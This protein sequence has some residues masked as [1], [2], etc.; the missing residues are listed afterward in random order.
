MKGRN[1]D[2]DDVK[3]AKD[4]LDSYIKEA[5]LITK[6]KMQEEIEAIRRQQND[7]VELTRIFE[8]NPSL[9]QHEEAIKALAKT[10]NSALEDIIVKYNFLSSDKLKKAKER[11]IVGSS[12]KEQDKVLDIK[13][14]TP[15]QWEKFKAEKGIG[16]KG[17]FSSSSSRSL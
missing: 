11:S 8:S 17:M 13:N 5:G 16:N 7:Q 6:D 9:K 3:A 2:P 10:D 14:M 12:S 4:F 15:E 1:E